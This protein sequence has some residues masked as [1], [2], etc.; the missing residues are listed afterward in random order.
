MRFAEYF[1]LDDS[2]IQCIS[3]A[4]DILFERNANAETVQTITCPQDEKSGLQYIFNPVPKCK[5]VKATNLLSCKFVCKCVSSDQICTQTCTIA[6]LLPSRDP[7]HL[8]FGTGLK[9]YCKSDFSSCGPQN[10]LTQVQ[11]PIAHFKNQFFN[12]KI[13]FINII[14][15][16]FWW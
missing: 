5:C 7:R 9:M 10:R 15:H 14:K 12:N 4:R 1:G 8:H 16:Q 11:I 2:D 6:N 3:N 13:S